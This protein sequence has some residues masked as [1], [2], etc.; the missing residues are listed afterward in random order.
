MGCSPY[1][2]LGALPSL[3]LVLISGQTSESLPLRNLQIVSLK[4]KNGLF[5][6]LSFGFTL[7]PGLRKE[8]ALTP[9][10]SPDPLRLGS[11]RST[12]TSKA[13]AKGREPGVFSFF[14]LLVQPGMSWYCWSFYVSLLS[15]K[16]QKR[17][18]LSNYQTKST[19]NHHLQASPT[20][21]LFFQTVF[22]TLETLM[23][24]KQTPLK[25]TQPLVGL[26][27]SEAPGSS[28]VMS[29][30]TWFQCSFVLVS[31]GQ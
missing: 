1:C 3:A 2:R 11:P 5:K 14:F 25:A 7:V 8:V 24:S 29:D 17:L 27:F 22:L 28:S 18:S 9:T 6:F 13:M 12:R 23:V 31:R 10:F 16:P 30:S 15:F 19:T 20:L 21:A 4:K 26:V